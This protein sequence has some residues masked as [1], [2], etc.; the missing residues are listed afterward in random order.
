MHVKYGDFSFYPWEANIAVDAEFRRAA[1]MMKHVQLVKYNISGEICEEGEYNVNSRLADMIAAFSVDDQDCG[2]F[3]SDNTPTEHFLD[4][5][6]PQNITGNFVYHKRLPPTVNGEFVSGRKFEFAVGA[7]LLDPGLDILEHHDNLS[8]V[9]NAGPEYRWDRDEWWGW[10]F[11]MVSPSTMQIIKH[12]GFRV[13]AYSWPLPVTPLY[14]PPF[15]AN[16][17]RSVD[18]TSPVIYTKGATGF[19]TSWE[20]TYTLPTFDDV[21]LPTLL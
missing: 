19:K 7:Y 11:K 5:N 15:E 10:Y 17:M 4:S 14:D 2:L 20:Y 3:H 1:T 8:R 9:S 6:I 13:G 21:S 16:H 12:T 18:F